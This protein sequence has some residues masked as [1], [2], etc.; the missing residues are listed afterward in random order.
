MSTP[1]PPAPAKLVVGL[2]MKERSLI[3]PLTEILVSRFGPLD[4]VSAWMRFDFTSYYAAEMGS[5]LFRRMLTFKELIAQDR[6]P[7]IKTATNGIETGFAEAGRRRVNIDPGYLLLERFVLASGK[8]FTHRIYIGQGI[9]A[10]LTLLFTRG[11]FETLPWTY[12]DYADPGMTA[13]LHQIRR[14][15]TL[16]LKATEP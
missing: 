14:R 13:H 12:P 15:Y 16:D 7:E 5:P 11:G 3:R 2:V 6:L 1:R 9:Y 10:D 4:M 8:N